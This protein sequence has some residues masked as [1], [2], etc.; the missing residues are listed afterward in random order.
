MPYCFPQRLHHFI[1]PHI[2]HGAFNFST[3]SPACLIF[4]FALCCLSSSHPNGCEVV[5]HC[6]FGIFLMITYL[7]SKGSMLWSRVREMMGLSWCCRRG[8]R[9]KGPVG[10]GEGREKGWTVPCPQQMWGTDR[11][12]EPFWG[13]IALTRWHKCTCSGSGEIQRGLCAYVWVFNRHHLKSVVVQANLTPESVQCPAHMLMGAG[14]SNRCR[15]CSHAAWFP[16]TCV[17]LLSIPFSSPV[18]KAP[19][20]R[21]VLPVL[22][23][24][25]EEG[26][27]GRAFPGPQ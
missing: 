1:F 13:I 21:H 25:Q 12:T 16:G 10:Q 15:R 3:S 27:P 17:F 4:C 19:P 2:E 8:G 7:I 14:I 26:P 11:S 9:D 6:V 22:W 24:A 18:P 20:I 5:P 23:G